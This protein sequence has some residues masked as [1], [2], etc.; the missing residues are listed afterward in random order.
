MLLILPDGA[1]LFDAPPTGGNNGLIGF[2]FAAVGAAI[3]G[4][5]KNKG[6]AAPPEAGGAANSGPFPVL[7]VVVEGIEVLELFCNQSSE[8]INEVSTETGA[9]GGVALETVGAGVGCKV[10]IDEALVPPLKRESPTPKAPVL[11]LEALVVV[12][13]GGNANGSPEATEV[14]A[15]V[16]VGL[17]EGVGKS[18]D[19]GNVPLAS[20]GFIASTVFP[21]VASAPPALPLLVA[22][23]P[24][25][26]GLNAMI[27]FEGDNGIAAAAGAILFLPPSELIDVEVLGAK[28][29]KFAEKLGSAT[30][31]VAVEELGAK[32]SKPVLLVDAV[33]GANPSFDETDGVNDAANPPLALLLRAKSKSLV[34]TGRVLAVVVGAKSKSFDGTAG[35]V[36]VLGA[37]SS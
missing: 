19:A 15:T 26:G 14:A 22:A 10:E 28:S 13:E 36:A 27:G 31:E 35:A 17:E 8:S 23:L 37:K 1:G 30:L 6:L 25:G 11:E 29:S 3:V 21:L 24:G 18:H 20:I 32:S 16:G 7:V 2:L 12:L 33:L 5:G 9:A 34:A 4:G